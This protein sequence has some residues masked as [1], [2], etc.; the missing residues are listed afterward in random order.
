MGAQS[1]RPV[2]D[3]QGTADSLNLMLKYMQAPVA[4]LNDYEPARQTPMVT[5]ESEDPIL[6]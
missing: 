6:D 1:G 4:E 5:I 2:L 3:H